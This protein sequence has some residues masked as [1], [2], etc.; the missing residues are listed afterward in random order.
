MLAPDGAPGPALI[1]RAD[2]AARLWAEGRARAI[3][4]TGGPA[5]AP[6]TEAEAMR[7]RLRERGV[8]D[9]A[10]LIEP[11]ARNTYENALFS[12][13]ILRGEGFGRALIVSDRYHLPRALMLFRVL[14]HPA[15]ASGPASEAARR[16]RLARMSWEAVAIPRDLG[17]GL[18]ARLAAHLR[19]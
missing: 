18:R 2:H 8:P 17:R 4:A 12:I 13:P 9:D 5:G 15:V 11:R 19:D 14:G 6:L 3:L 7:R 1:R 16:D 10:I